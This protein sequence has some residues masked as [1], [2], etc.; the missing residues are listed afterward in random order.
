LQQLAPAFEDG[1]AAEAGDTRQR[2]DRAAALLMSQEAKQQTALAFIG[3]PG[4]AV[5]QA[6][7]QGRSAAR[8][9]SA[10]SATALV[11]LLLGG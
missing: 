6:M 10:I 4:Q 1:G 8:V 11:G 2:T 3:S 5:D 9:L 7:L